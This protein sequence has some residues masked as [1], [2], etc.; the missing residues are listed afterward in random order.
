ML[1]CFDEVPPPRG[2]FVAWA[3]SELELDGWVPKM[4]VPRNRVN[5]VTL[6][7]YHDPA[8]DHFCLLLVGQRNHESCPHSKG[9]NHRSHHW[10]VE[11]NVQL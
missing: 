9:E 1:A 8:L 5:Q 6:Y 2:L 7:P 11:N 4:S 10:W 3:S